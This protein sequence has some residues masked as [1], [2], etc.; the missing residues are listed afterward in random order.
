MNSNLLV[1]LLMT[2]FAT[3]CP[4]VPVAE[5]PDRPDARN[6]DRDDDGV[7]DADDACPAEYGL[8][9][10]GCPDTPSVR[11][12]DDDG[13][14]AAFETMRSHR[15]SPDYFVSDAAVGRAVDGLRAGSADL[16]LRVK[17]LLADKAKARAELD[18]AQA[19]ADA[20]TKAAGSDPDG[21]GRMLES[22]L[23]LRA[24][25]RAHERLDTQLGAALDALGASLR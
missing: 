12:N 11:V 24:A 7:A 8:G 19:E 22:N 6:R 2:S 10:N 18:R 20:A 25:E 14:R 5:R 17:S 1:A 9:P 13:G 16:K 15:A 3:A 21:I 4:S 23:T